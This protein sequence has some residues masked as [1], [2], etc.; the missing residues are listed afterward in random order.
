MKVYLLRCDDNDSYKATARKTL[1]DWIKTQGASSTSQTPGSSQEKHDAFEW[2]ILHVVQDG[3]GSEKVPASTSKWGRGTTTVLEKIKAD[4]NGSSKTAVDRVAQLRLPKDATAK[5]PELTEQLEDL[6]DKMKNGI[7]ASFDLRVAQYEEDIKEKDSQRSLPGWNFCTFFI[8]KEGLARGFENVGLFED[9]LVGYDELSVGLDAAI[10]DQLQGPGEQHGNALLTSSKGFVENAKKAL[11]S[12]ESTDSVDIENHSVLDILPEDFPLSSSKMPYREMILSSDISIF[13]FR[14]YVFSRQL[15]LLLR[16]ARAPSLGLNDPATRDKKQEDFIMLS[17]ICARSTEFV[18]LA[19]RTLRYDLESGLRE[20]ENNAKVNIISNMVSS[21]TYSAALQILNQTFT[22]GLKIPESSIHA[23][24]QAAEASVAEIRADAPRRTSSLIQSV[25]NRPNRPV[26]QDLSDVGSLQR[27]STL[28]HPKSAH[29][30]PQRTG[31]EQLASG[32]GELLLLARRSLE[33]I[34]HRRGWSEKWSDLGL[35]FDDSHRSG[36][37]DLTDV[38]LDADDSLEPQAKANSKKTSLAGIDLSTLKASLES[39]DTFLTYYEDLTDYIIRHNTA[40]GRT[41]SA[42]L[43]LAD[44]AILRFRQGD[45]ESAAA[46]FHQMAPFYGNKLWVVL[47]GTMLELYSR[48]LKKL[49]RNEDYVRIMLRLLSKFA[50]HSQSRLS[51]RQKALSTPTSPS[52]QEQLSVYVSD[53][54]EGLGVLQKDITAPL[55]DWFADLSVDPVIQLYDDKDGLQI[56]MSLRFLLGPQIDIDSIKVRLVSA[57]TSQNTEL[58]VE[59]SK[60][61]TIKSTKTKILVDCSVCIEFLRN[62]FPAT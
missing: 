38:S 41:N 62:I 59:V 37:K 15:T 42:E 26:T 19:A 58:W 46:Y 56:Q 22:P 14:T 10:R 39:K 5:S 2:L 45:Y 53:L 50:Q 8:L 13:N 55:S 23:V 33:E 31:S 32:R 1:R 4:F 51:D 54:F 9:A 29:A 47:E 43:A 52:E 44:I 49:K 24:T 17:E 20:V 36:A 6:I 7:L 11:E 48:C 35:L 28:D 61:F 25:A 3:D 30:L 57:N 27:R 60:S 12:G 16:A 21:W 18:S 40:A 34:A